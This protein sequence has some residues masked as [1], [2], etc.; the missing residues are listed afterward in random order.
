MSN[1]ENFKMID[2]IILSRPICRHLKLWNPSII[3]R[4][5]GGR[6]NSSH[7]EQTE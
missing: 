6:K 5:K 7:R 2:L 3:V 4:L 1:F